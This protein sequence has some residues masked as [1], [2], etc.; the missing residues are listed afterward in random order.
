MFFLPNNSFFS[1]ENTNKAV[2]A[3]FFQDSNDKCTT[4]FAATA[5]FNGYAGALAYFIFLKL[6]R[7]G[8]ECMHL[9]CVFSTFGSCEHI[10]SFIILFYFWKYGSW[11]LS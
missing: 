9:S 8:V 11:I 6:P 7:Q 2:I 1:Q 4:A 5:F 3:D 10:F